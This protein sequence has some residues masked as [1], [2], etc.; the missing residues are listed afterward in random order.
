M[1]N[2]RIICLNLM[3]IKLKKKCLERDCLLDAI[4]PETATVLI[5][6]VLCGYSVIQIIKGC[7]LIQCWNFALICLNKHFDYQDGCEILTLETCYKNTKC[8]KNIERRM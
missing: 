1:Y 7:I 6:H 3:Y 8:Y 5:C 4:I 2:C